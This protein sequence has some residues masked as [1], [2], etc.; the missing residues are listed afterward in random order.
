MYNMV[1]DEL[2]PQGALLPKYGFA[3]VFIVCRMES[4]TL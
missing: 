1:G 3:R 2:E 4:P